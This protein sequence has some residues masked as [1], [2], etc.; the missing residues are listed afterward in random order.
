MGIVDVDFQAVRAVRAA[1]DELAALAQA[2][3]D[4]DC[5]AS[6]E[7]WIQ[8][9]MFDEQSPANDVDASSD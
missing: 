2:H 5:P 6:V 8:L 4:L 1:R 7:G 3:P 9:L